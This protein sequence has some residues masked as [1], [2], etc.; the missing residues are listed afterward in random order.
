MARP[1][2]TD[3]YQNFRFHVFLSAAGTGESLPDLLNKA[4]G[5]GFQAVTMPT[6]SVESIEFMFSNGNFL[7]YLHSTK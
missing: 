5:A 3:P 2:N 6:A 4:N 1:H 7:G